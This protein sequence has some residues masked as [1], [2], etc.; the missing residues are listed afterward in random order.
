MRVRAVT[1]SIRSILSRAVAATCA[2]NSCREGLAADGAT[3]ARLALMDGF[4]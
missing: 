4:L 3:A 2:D 1:C